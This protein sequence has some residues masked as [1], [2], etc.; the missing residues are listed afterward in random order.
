[1]SLYV[2]LSVI[3]LNNL[4]VYMSV[5]R[6][7]GWF[8]CVCVS[9]Y[10]LCVRKYVRHEGDSQMHKQI[11]QSRIVFTNSNENNECRMW[12]IAH[13]D[14]LIGIDVPCY[15]SRNHHWDESDD[16]K[17]DSERLDKI[18]I[19]F[20]SRNNLYFLALYLVTLILRSGC[21]NAIWKRYKKESY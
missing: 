20:D 16:L 9:V 10:T 14:C 8:L 3:L 19:I 12:N 11:Q 6:S 7:V 5:Y 4:S 21:A 17:D 13:R 1:M 2:C 18:W 15:S